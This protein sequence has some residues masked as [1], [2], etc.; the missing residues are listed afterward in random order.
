MFIVLPIIFFILTTLLIEGYQKD[1]RQSLLFSAVV[2]G[3]FRYCYYGNPE[4]FYAIQ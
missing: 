4:C 1:I 2:F 3:F